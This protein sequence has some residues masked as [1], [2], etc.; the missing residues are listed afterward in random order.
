MVDRSFELF[1]EGIDPLRQGGRMGGVLMQY[2]PY[3]TA[4]DREHE[5]RNLATIER[6]VEM[7][8]PLP[9]FVEFRHSS[10][11]EGK[12][13]ERTMRFLVGAL[14]DLRRRRCAAT[15]GCAT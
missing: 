3:F 12:Q 14:P 6:A 9:L 7:L 2:P 15:G 10:W 1:L 13:L 4:V 11:V 8:K 5:R